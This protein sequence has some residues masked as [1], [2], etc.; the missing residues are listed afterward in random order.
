MKNEPIDT[1]AWTQIP[2]FFLKYEYILT[3]IVFREVNKYT[4][5]MKRKYDSREQRG[6]HLTLSMLL[7]GKRRSEVINKIS[8]YFRPWETLSSAISC[9]AETTRTPI[10]IVLSHL[11]FSQQVLSPRDHHDATHYVELRDVHS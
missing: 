11:L 4:P 10:V 5:G 2:L 1:V 3:Q 6:I 8:S 9:L 7:F